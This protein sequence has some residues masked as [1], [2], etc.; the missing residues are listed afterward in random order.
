MLCAKTFINATQHIKEVAV[1]QPKQLEIPTPGVRE[2]ERET[3]RDFELNYFPLLLIL[4]TRGNFIL[5][6]LTKMRAA[7]VFQMLFSEAEE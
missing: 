2:T 5:I 1:L 7:T 6:Y 4:L 3:Q